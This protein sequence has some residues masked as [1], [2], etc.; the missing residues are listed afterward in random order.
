MSH[1]LSFIAS[2]TVFLSAAGTWEFEGAV[3]VWVRREVD[4]A[5]DLQVAH[6]LEW[7][8]PIVVREKVGRALLVLVAL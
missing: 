5:D 2:V 3:L 8:P 7:I 4:R 6:P 1:F